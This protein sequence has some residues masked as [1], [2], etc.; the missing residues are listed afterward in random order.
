PRSARRSRTRRSTRTTPTSCIA[1]SG[2]R[3]CGTGSPG[4][5]S[6]SP[7]WAPGTRSA[8]ELEPLTATIAAK[9]FP[10]ATVQNVGYEQARIPQGSQD[11]VISNVPFGDYGVTDDLMPEFLRKPIHNYFFAK[12]LQHVRP[13]GLI[14]FVTSR[15]TMD[16]TEHTRFRQHV[17]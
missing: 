3:W 8:V 11:L 4:A 17:M 6:S 12:A 9:L 13:G 7:R 1:R 14:V 15:Y 10:S 2:T 16:G 5:A